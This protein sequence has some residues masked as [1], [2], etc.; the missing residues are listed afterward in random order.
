MV[1]DFRRFALNFSD[2]TVALPQKSRFISEVGD[3]TFKYSDDQPRDDHGRWTNGG[4]TLDERLVDFKP[5]RS[6]SDP[7]KIESI[8][9]ALLSTQVNAQYE[10]YS[11]MPFL[12][13][14]HQEMGVADP[15]S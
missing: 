11:Q 3:F 4:G 12:G 13:S 14:L 8:S 5:D 9:T 15:L 1:A 7:S 2:L 6:L 10:A